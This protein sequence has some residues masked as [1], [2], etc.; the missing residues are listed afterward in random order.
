[1]Q[2]VVGTATM[3]AWSSSDKGGNC[4]RMTKNIHYPAT[5][6]WALSSHPARPSELRTGT[7]GGI[8]RWRSE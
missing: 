3:M 5:S 6:A 1:M 2:S 7:D 8:M 4:S